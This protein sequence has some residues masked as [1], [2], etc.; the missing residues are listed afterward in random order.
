MLLRIADAEG[1]RE[2]RITLQFRTWKRPTVKAGTLAGIPDP[3]PTSLAM[4][5]SSTDW[6]TV[7]R[8]TCR[9]TAS[10]VRWPTDARC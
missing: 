3:S 7:P 5:G 8:Y 2:G 10:S 9:G 4:F 6:T 1:I